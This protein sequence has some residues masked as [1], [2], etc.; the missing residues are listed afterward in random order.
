MYRVGWPGALM[1]GRL[2]VPLEIK[3]FIRFD[4]EARVF[5]GVSDDIRGLVVEGASLDEIAK[6]VEELVPALMASDQKTG[7]KMAP[8]RT[9]ICYSA[10]VHC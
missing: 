4:E 6:E 7:R 10:P 9:N 8:A 1:L 5:V 3:V 2:G